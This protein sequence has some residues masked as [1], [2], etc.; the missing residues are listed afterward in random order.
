MQ[1][2]FRKT[3]LVTF[4]HVLNAFNRIY[5][6][7]PSLSGLGVHRNVG[8][9]TMAHVSVIFDIANS[10]RL[11]LPNVKTSPITKPVIASANS[12]GIFAVL[13]STIF[14]LPSIFITQK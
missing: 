11:H 10:K 5:S 7:I 13:I 2:G 4:Y 3:G 8:K 9:H 12:L 14:T 6:I 1:E